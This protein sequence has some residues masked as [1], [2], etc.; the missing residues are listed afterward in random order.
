MS[1]EHA[2]K[3]TAIDDFDLGE[4]AAANTAELAIIHPKTKAETGW[5]WTFAG[6]GHPQTQELWN[7]LGMRDR[8][9]D[10]ANDKA[11]RSGRDPKIPTNPE[12]VEINVPRYA[13]RALHFT[14]V[15]LNGRMIEFSPEEAH[16]LLKNPNYGWLWVQVYNFLNA[17]DSFI[18][19][20]PT[21]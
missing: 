20:S 14:P 7:K 8:A 15:K 18:E 12:L 21:T 9:K 10:F 16:R 1:D 3:L 2:E 5:V 4:L 19:A 17:E 13:G 6:P 11:I